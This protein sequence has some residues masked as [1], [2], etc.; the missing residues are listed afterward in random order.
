MQVPQLRVRRGAGPRAARQG[1]CAGAPGILL[2]FRRA[3]PSSSSASWSSRRA[4][5]RAIARVL[6]RATGAAVVRRRQ[7]GISVPLFAI[8][9]SSG[10]GIGEFADL[11]MFARWLPGGRPVDRADPADQRDAADRNLAVFGDDGDGARS[12]LHHDGERPR[13]RRHRRRARA[14]R[15]RAGGDCSA[16]ASRQPHRVRRRSGG[17]RRSGCGAASIASSSSKCRAARRGRGGS[18]RSP[19]AQ[20]W[21]LDEY[22]L[23]RSIHALHDE[24]AVDRLAGA[25]GA[26]R[27]AGVDRRARIARRSRSNIART[28][29]GSPPSSGRR[30]SGC[31]GRCACSAICRS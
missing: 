2:R 17:S 30:P 25:A 20:S 15:R 8:A 13:L 29:S 5:D 19:P 4:F 16:C 28:C 21:W 12:D 10:W 31:R 23:F 6:A 18:T 3:R 11:P 26:R 22:A 1:R 7:S 27:G 14:R 24:R 9:S